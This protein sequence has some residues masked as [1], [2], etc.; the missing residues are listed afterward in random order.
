M[1][2]ISVED[3]LAGVT[4]AAAVG[5]EVTWVAAD[6]AVAILE[7]AVS[8]VSLVE[9]SAVEEP[10]DLTLDRRNLEVW[11][12]PMRVEESDARVDHRELVNLVAE[13]LPAV[14]WWVDRIRL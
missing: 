14:M 10:L 9:V 8:V 2:A 7:E 4:S 3:I 5:A 6:S 13:S 1:V 12:G 11:F